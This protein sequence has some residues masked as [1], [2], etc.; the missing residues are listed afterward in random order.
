MKDHLQNKV[1]HV[2]RMNSNGISLWTLEFTTSALPLYA[3]LKRNKTLLIPTE[4]YVHNADMFVDIA[5][6]LEVEIMY[7]AFRMLPLFPSSGSVRRY[8][9]V[10]NR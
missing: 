9:L 10:R 6:S 7:K 4:T 1:T 5:D 2:T 3:A 8:L